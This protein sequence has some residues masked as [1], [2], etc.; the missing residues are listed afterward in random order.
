MVVVLF[1]LLL[2]EATTINKEIIN[3]PITVLCYID[4]LALESFA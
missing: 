3:F 2:V 4:F 1:L